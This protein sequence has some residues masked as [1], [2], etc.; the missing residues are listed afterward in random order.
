MCNRINDKNA[1]KNVLVVGTAKDCAQYLKADIYK[2]QS[3]LADFKQVYWLVI[4]SD[5]KDTTLQVLNKLALEIHHFRYLSLGSLSGK[6]PLRTERIAHCRNAYLKE[7]RENPLYEAIK[8]VVVADLDGANNLISPQAIA[9][10]FTRDDWDV[11]T[12]NQQGP[13][14]DIWALRHEAWCPNDCW[15]QAEFL[16]RYGLRQKQ[17]KFSSVFSKMLVIPPKSLW[18]EV[19][20]AFGGLAIYRR[21]ALEKANYVGIRNDGTEI[22]EHVTLHQQIKNQGFSIFINPAL[23]NVETKKYSKKGCKKIKRPGLLKRLFTRFE[24]S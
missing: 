15:Q 7:L 12:A 13:Y 5:S 10:C 1:A 17:A 18:I 3:A 14:Y 16:H 24:K 8:W 23:I 19:D 11:C 6:L 21:C 20:S 9:S 2:L 22:C 4:E